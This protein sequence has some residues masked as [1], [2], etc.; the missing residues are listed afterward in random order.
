MNERDGPVIVGCVPIAVTAMVLLFAAPETAVPAQLKCESRSLRQDDEAL[1]RAAA[2]A[3][4]PK[5]VRLQSVGS[6]RNPD[7]ALAFIETRR[8]EAAGGVRQWWELIC[9]RDARYW[10]C[11]PPE[12][13]QLI[14]LALVVDGLLREVELSFDKDTQLER[15]R[16]LA[17]KALA[18]Y[19]DPAVRLP[20]CEAKKP[21][22]SD[23]YD[24]HRGNRLPTGKESIHI[25]V[26]HTTDRDEVTLDDVYVAIGFAVGPDEATRSTAVCWN[27][28]IVVT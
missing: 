14:Q 9:R 15:G 21:T 10:K 25:S 24:V 2:L 22:V 3:V 13:K 23:L 1:A 8:T 20:G 18:I 17:A 6:C 4:L 27:D 19:V 28:V 7:R 5:G 16:S 11:D 26:V 12:F